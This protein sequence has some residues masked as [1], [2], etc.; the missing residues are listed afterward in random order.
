MIF[1]KILYFSFVGVQARKDSLTSEKID[2]IQ[3]TITRNSIRH[4]VG[5]LRKYIYT[6]TV[7]I[8]YK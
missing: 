8:K 7:E 3:V 6:N 5:G 4:S 1:F 2:T